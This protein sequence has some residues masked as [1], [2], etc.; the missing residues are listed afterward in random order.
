MMH[1]HKLHISR[2]ERVPDGMGGYTPGAEIVVWSGRADVQDGGRR[3]VLE[4]G[5]LAHE[6]DARA[7]L[8]EPPTRIRPGDRA[9]IEWEDGSVEAAVVA[10]VHRLDES[11][12]LRYGDD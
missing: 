10:R 12:I 6:G 4:G 7:F 9:R 1:P 8:A 3:M 5:L 2:R 11:L